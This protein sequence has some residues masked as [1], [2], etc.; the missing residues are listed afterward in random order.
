MRPTRFFRQY[1][2]RLTLFT[3]DNCGL[4]D[5]AKGI[6]RTV[7]DKRPFEFDVVDVMHGN[8]SKWKEVYEFDTPVVSIIRLHLPKMQKAGVTLMFLFG[9]L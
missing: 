7:W 6:L 8:N 4:C 2:C 3:R 5:N 1:V 9:I